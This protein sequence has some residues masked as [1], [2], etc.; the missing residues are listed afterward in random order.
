MSPRKW[1]VGV[2]AFALVAFAAGCGGGNSNMP[3][4]QPQSGSIFIS[5]TDA[6]L[7]S[8]VSCKFTIMGISVA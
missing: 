4:V 7:Q 3:P 5:G 2:Y 8:V 1:L 6:P